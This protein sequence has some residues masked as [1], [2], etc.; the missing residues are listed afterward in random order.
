METGRVCGRSPESRTAI[1]GASVTRLT[2]A[3]IDGGRSKKL[4]PIALATAD[5]LRRIVQ[6]EPC[7]D[8]AFASETAFLEAHEPRS[9]KPRPFLILCDCTGKSL[10]STAFAERLRSLRDAGKRSVTL[11]IGPASGWSPV[12]LARADLLLS[13]GPMT[14]PHALARLILAEQIYRAMTILAGHP[15]HTGH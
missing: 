12:A 9:G 10:S 7:D 2:L 3:S 6:F 5:Y 4:D 15:Y 1:P 14:L 11:A 13:F 8:R